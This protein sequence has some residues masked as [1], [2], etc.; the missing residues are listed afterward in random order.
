MRVI[1]AQILF[2]LV[3][4]LVLNAGDAWSVRLKELADLQGVRS[5]HLIGYGLVVGLN[6][7]GDSDDNGFTSQ[8]MANMLER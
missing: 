5:N 6:D 3:I 7:T 2:L 4:G 1:P 8:T